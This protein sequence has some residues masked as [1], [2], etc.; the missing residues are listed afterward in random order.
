MVAAQT[1]FLGGPRVMSNMAVDRWLPRRFMNL[2]ERLVMKDGILVMGLSA[3]AM[4]LYTH[5]SV[6]ILVVMYS[7]N[8]F[9]TFTLSQFG[10]VRYWW[11]NHGRGWVKGLLINGTGM[12][13]TIGILIVTTALKFRE[14]GW[15]TMGVTG[16]LIG[17]CFAV[18]RHYHDTLIALRDLNKVMGSLPVKELAE[19]PA[20]QPNAHT[21]VLLVSGYNGVGIHSILEIQRFFP[22]HFKNFVFLSVG[23]I[24]SDRFKGRAEIDALMRSVE[25]DL[26]KYKRL[27]NSMGFYAEW[28]ADLGTDVIT[29]LDHLCQRVDD[30]WD[31]KVF[32]MG[33][34]AFE[35][36]TFW[37]RLLH[38]Q[39]SFILHRKL[40][41]NGL[42]AVILPIRLR[43]EEA[44]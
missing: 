23:I 26:S 30:E 12:A 20:K 31:K 32:F 22:G 39:T 10:M 43:L 7:I 8:V 25:Q 34:L 2:S 13:L 16:C 28:K 17:V 35:G 27:A 18:R 21:A 4:I 14:G 24:D 44:T 29:G 33:Q 38:N 6:K 37:T 15:V 40:L 36:E 5:A 1:G 19:A 41:F 11:A 9:V 42:A 3:I